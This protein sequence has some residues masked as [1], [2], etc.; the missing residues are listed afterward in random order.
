LD[1][2]TFE[3]KS[4]KDVTVHCKAVIIAAGVGAFGPNKPPLHNIDDF[5]NKSIHYYVK[6]R[7]MYTGKDI[8]IAGGGDSALDWAI[9]LSEIAKS[10]SLVHRRA[11]FTAAPDSVAKLQALSNSGRIKCVVPYQLSD[12]K[13]HDGVLEEV[14]VKSLDG[15]LLTLKAD[16]LLPFYGLSMNLGPILNFGLLM[17][18]NH[19]HINPL[20]AETSIPGIYA[21]GDITSYDHKLKLIL[22][23]FAEA[24]QASHAIRRQ[25]FPDE[26]VHFE[27]STTKGLPIG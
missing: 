27:Y 21:I 26:V 5:E 19:I 18:K 7:Q 16:Y 25:L 13:G 3:I 23:G 22:T 4:D 10:V 11:K 12:L 15:S 20:T 6:S 9:S 8:V 1:D 24:A 2:A 14:I 17:D